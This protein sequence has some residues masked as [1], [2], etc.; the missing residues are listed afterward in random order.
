MHAY[1][2]TY[3]HTYIH[4]HADR[5]NKKRVMK[6]LIEMNLAI[7]TVL[8]EARGNDAYVH[9]LQIWIRIHIFIWILEKSLKKLPKLKRFFPFNK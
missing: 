3:I 6:S 1:I 9:F 7:A 4:L 8:I 5:H 2:H